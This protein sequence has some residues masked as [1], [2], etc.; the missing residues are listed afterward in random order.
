MSEIHSF[1]SEL[2]DEKLGIQ[3]N[4]STCPFLQDT[5]SSPKL[6]NSMR[7]TCEGQL[8]CS[9]CFKVLSTFSNDKT[10]GNDGLTVEFYKIFWSE[11]GTFLVDSLNY[12]YFHGK[13][14]NLQ[15]QAVITLIEKKDK[16]K[17]WIKDWRPISLGNVDVKIGSKAIAKRL[18]TL[19]PHIIHYD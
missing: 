15:K 9:E 2:Y 13:L 5:L 12:A 7:E 18:E 4:Y 6:T 19:L 3:N 8:T 1:H 14:S 16:D 17:R 10:P 11:I